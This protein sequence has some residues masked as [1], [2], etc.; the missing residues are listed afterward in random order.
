MSNVT[1][2]SNED[3]GG[4]EILVRFQVLTAANM[5]ITIFWDVADIT[6][7]MEA[8]STSENIGQF[9]QDYTAQHPRR[10]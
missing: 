1:V 8:V 2:I 3:C 7:M 4:C 9:L 10:Q 6:L 5:M